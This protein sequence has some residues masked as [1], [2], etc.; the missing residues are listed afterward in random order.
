V[1]LPTEPS[2]QPLNSH[3]KGPRVSTEH[4][5][6]ANF[7][8]KGD[9]LPQRDKWMG[10]VPWIRQKKQKVFLQMWFLRQKGEGYGKLVSP[11]YTC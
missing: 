8:Y 1:L 10:E 3:F 11:D 7:Q 4:N 5:Q 9:L 6:T 2:H